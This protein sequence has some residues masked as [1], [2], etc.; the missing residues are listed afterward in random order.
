MENDRLI[1]EIMK[2][3]IFWSETTPGVVEFTTIFKRQACLLRMNDFPDEVTYTLTMGNETASF[4][5]L[6]KGWNLRP[7]KG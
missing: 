1:D 2:G 4:D 3:Q 5:D 7:K 6:P